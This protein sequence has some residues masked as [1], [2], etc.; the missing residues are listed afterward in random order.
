MAGVKVEILGK[1]YLLRSDRGE[2]QV[3]RAAGYL[4][5]RL[6]EVLSQT[7][8]SSTLSATVLAALNVTS[9]LLVLKDEKE[10]LLREIEVRAQ[11]LLQKIEQA[12]E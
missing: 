11:R 9:E 1:E 4:D 8:T 12:V 5:D 10:S 2:A 7:T 6:N 3:R